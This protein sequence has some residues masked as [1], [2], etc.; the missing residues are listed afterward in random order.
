MIRMIKTQ[1][2][3]GIILRKN[4]IILASQHGTS[5]SLPKGHIENGENEIDAAKREIYEETGITKLRLIKK[6]GSYQRYKLDKYG[7]ENKNEL[8]TIHLFYSKQLKR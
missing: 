4:S 2:A 5:W 7:E 8:K 3:G 6:L 1:S